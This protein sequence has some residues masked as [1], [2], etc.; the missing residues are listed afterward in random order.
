MRGGVVK[1]IMISM[2]LAVPGAMYF[3]DT[4]LWFSWT[5]GCLSTALAWWMRL[6]KVRPRARMRAA[7]VPRARCVCLQRLGAC[8]RLLLRLRQCLCLHA[9][10]HMHVLYGACTRPG[11]L[12]VRPGQLL[13][14]ELRALQQ[15]APL[16]AGHP[17]PNP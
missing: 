3:I 12:M 16:Q 7:C 6:G 15:D 10:V 9:P 14:R 1:A 11:E 17:K 13:R 4:Y 5:T 8:L 2:R